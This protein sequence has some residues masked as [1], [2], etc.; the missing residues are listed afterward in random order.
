MPTEVSELLGGE[1]VLGASVKS[2]LDLA[3]ATREG[4]PA[5]TAIKLAA[6]ILDFEGRGDSSSGK[7]VAAASYATLL[8]SLVREPSKAPEDHPVP[9]RLTPAESDL[10]IRVA[11]VIARAIDVL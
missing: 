11:S 2:N 6:L 1:Q 9:E 4:L 5:A 3:R 8:S 10:V 7:E